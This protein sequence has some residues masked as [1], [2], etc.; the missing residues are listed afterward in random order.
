LLA[1]LHAFNHFKH[2][3]ADIFSL[4]KAFIWRIYTFLNY[5]L[6]NVVSRIIISTWRLCFVYLLL[7][8][9]FFLW[10]VQFYLN[11]VVHFFYCSL[12]LRFLFISLL[13]SWTW[14]LFFKVQSFRH[15]LTF[16]CF[17]SFVYFLWLKNSNVLILYFWI[18][19]LV[20]N[21]TFL[22]CR[23]VGFLLVD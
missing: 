20:F 19:F 22:I 7:W 3:L 15:D 17:F 5:T 2:L 10:C 12:F 23:Q 13:L 9:L 8:R 4:W 11:V 1:L 21:K 6:R 18:S 16:A 14:W